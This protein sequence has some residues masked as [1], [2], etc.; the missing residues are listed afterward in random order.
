M[1]NK[2]LIL[3]IFI[4][5]VMI[6][7]CI[8]NNN[9]EKTIIVFCGSVS[10]PAIEEAAK[11]FE[12]KEKIKVE[13]NF[14]GSGTMLSNM[15]I[16]RKGDLYIPASPD[17][18]EKAKREKVVDPESIKIISYI[19]P[20][21]IVQKGNPKNIKT[22]EDLAKPNIKVGIA[23]PES[24]SIGVYTVELLEYNHLTKKV[25]KNIV[26]H[27]K[28]FSDALSLIS[29]KKV[30]AIIGWQ[31]AEKWNLDYLEV[32]HINPDKIP[33][34]AYVS[35]AISTYSKDRKSA[36]NFLDFL[37][38]EEG[39]NIFAKHGYLAT[40]AEARKYAPNAE[41]GGEYKLP[42]DR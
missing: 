1:N 13:L 29:T 7:G 25:E 22:L 16:S 31:V 35:S 18:M 39:K 19:V 2:I 5:G 12:E 17:Y 10:K 42:K 23:N 30:D 20:A 9:N 14:G 8:E 33:R 40:E 36:K 26:T 3:S 4:A 24:V 38:S 15:E 34:V 37:V 27:T 11:V 28:S 21:I 32:V 41:I 6:S